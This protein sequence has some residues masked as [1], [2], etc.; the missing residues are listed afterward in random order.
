MPGQERLQPIVGRRVDRQ[1]FA[2]IVQFRS[3]SRRADVKVLDVSAFGARISG[4][5][6]VRQ[7]DQF[8]LKLPMIEAIPAQIVWVEEFE[9]GC[10]FARPLNQIILDAIIRQHP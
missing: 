10:E 6:Q 5:F 8:F 4:V 2:A 7:G 9:F 1:P 3:G